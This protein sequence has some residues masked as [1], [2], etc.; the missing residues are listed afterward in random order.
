MYGELS[1]R[2]FA[3]IIALLGLG[4]L[5]PL[6]L[7]AYFLYLG[8]T[9]MMYAILAL[10]LDLLLGW[11]GQFAFAHIAFF[12]IGIYATALLQMRLGVPFI[13]GVAIAAAL[14][15][16]VGLLIAIPATR[17]RTVY[18]A[19]ATYA[20]AECAQWVLRTWDSLTKGSDGLRF[21][22]PEILGYVVDT[23]RRAFPL[24]ALILALVL[25]SFL[26]LTRSQLGRALCAIRDSEHVAAASGIGVKRTKVIAF[27]LS[28]VFAGI[29]GGSYT[30]YQSYVTPDSVGLAQL[31]LVLTM[32]VVGGSGSI[33]GVL[34]GVVLIGLLPEVLRAAPRGLLVWQEFFYGLILILATMFMPRGLWGFA[35]TM[36]ARPR[37]SARSA[38]TPPAAPATAGVQRSTP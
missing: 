38:A 6:L 19:L 11:S 18:L 10:G 22:P 1:F 9:L 5:L 33:A 12:G 23:D 35:A 2:S 3:G 37:P 17:L 21:S 14:A 30:L 32:V 28:A 31:I 24:M 26:Y 13:L 25:L 15:G 36:F 34:I 16:L 29:A 20:F 27:V 4:V 8:N 7:P